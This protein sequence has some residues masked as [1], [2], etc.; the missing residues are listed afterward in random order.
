MSLHLEAATL[1]TI[2]ELQVLLITGALLLLTT[3]APPL[4]TITALLPRLITEER[5][6]LTIDLAHRAGQITTPLH[7]VL[8]VGLALEEAAVLVLR[9]GAQ[10]DLPALV[11]ADPEEEGEINFPFFF[12]TIPHKKVYSP[13]IPY[14]QTII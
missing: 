5:A 10:G 12:E 1:T 9:A 7:S 13:F 2:P 3:E 8:Q 4:L 6:H 14:H 11:L